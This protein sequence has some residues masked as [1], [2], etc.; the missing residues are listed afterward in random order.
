MKTCDVWIFHVG[1]G[2]ASALRTPGGNWIVIDLGAREDFCPVEDFLLNHIP[3]KAGDQ[4]RR[5]A[6]LIISHP[7]DDHMTALK[8][9]H[10]QYY[11]QL[12]TV[13]NDNDGQHDMKKVDWTLIQNPKDDLTNYLRSEV[14]PGRQPPLKATTDSSTGF[15]FE[16][17]YL[18]PH[19][20]K[21]DT[22]LLKTNYANNISIVARLYYQG[23][24]VLF[25]GDVMKDGMKKLIEKTGLGKRLEDVGVKFLVAPHHGLRSAFSVDLFAKMKKGKAGLNI[26]SEKETISGSNEIVD[27]RYGKEEYASGHPVRIDGKSEQKRKLRTSVVGHIHIALFENG[28]SLVTTGDGVI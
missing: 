9:F 20:C 26:I 5:L 8:R 24:V 19:V 25:S 15:N 28:R 11:P 17:F 10:E 14:L 2:F 1:R 6:Q 23:N 13:P 27:E 4:K 21:T 16:I 7:H 3:A 18:D 22:E 12:L